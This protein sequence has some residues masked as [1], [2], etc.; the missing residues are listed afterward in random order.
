MGDDDLMLLRK[1]SKCLAGLSNVPPLII[2]SKRL[3]S[4]EKGI[5]TQRY[6]DPHGITPSVNR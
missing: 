4:P 3:T 1:G 5:S 6:H 2:R